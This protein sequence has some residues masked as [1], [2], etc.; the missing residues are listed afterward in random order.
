MN[1][2]A[3]TRI[4]AL[5]IV[6]TLSG[7]PI[8]NAMCVAWCGQFEAGMAGRERVAAPM[9]ATISDGSG[10]CA[11]LLADTPFLREEGRIKFLAVSNG[12]LHAPDAPL[13][14]EGSRAHTGRDWN[15]MR[16]W[17]QPAHVLRL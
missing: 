5:L 16:G 14:V 1:A 15:A 3:M 12:E 13:A 2:T 9:S 7:G 10:T 17:P 11:V 8:A 6:L 4:S